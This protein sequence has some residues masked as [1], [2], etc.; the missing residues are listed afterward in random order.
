[1][2]NTRNKMTDLRN[3]LFETLEALKDEEKPMDLKRAHAIS[4]VAQTIIE[5]AKVEV[6]FL[7]VMNVDSGSEFFETPEE[8]GMRRKLPARDANGMGKYPARIGEVR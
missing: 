3:H 2:S 4:E 5:S 6:E 7:N 8:I 1:M